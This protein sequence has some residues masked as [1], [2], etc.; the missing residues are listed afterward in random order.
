MGDVILDLYEV[1][2]II[3]EGGFG[4]VYKVYHKDWHTELAVKSPNENTLAER[5]YLRRYLREA[6][7]WIDLGLHPNIVSCYYVRDL[8][9][10]P[11]IFME[12][13]PGGSL[14]DRISQGIDLKDALD[15]AIQICRGMA[16]AH[17]KKPHSP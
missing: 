15:L 9:G 7:V 3:G 1:Q 6:E 4:T 10:I 14:K 2:D 11:R 17:K 13:V 8:G 5:E 16:Y 12:Y